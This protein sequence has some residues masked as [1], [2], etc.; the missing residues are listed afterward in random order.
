MSEWLASTGETNATVEQVA[1]VDPDRTIETYAA[2]IGLDASYEAFMTEAEKQSKYNWR[3]ELTAA[4]VNA[5]VRA[6][7]EV[8]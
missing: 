8:Q 1:F 4:S 2:S 3:P 6:G 7:F 5:Y